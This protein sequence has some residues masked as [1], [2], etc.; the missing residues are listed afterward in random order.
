MELICVPRKIRDTR[1]LNY[2]R[3]LRRNMTA[4]ERRLWY[5]YLREHPMYRFRRQEIIGP[6]IADFYCARH[7]LVIEIDGS[8]HYEEDALAYDAARTAYF[9]RQQIRVIRFTTT[10]IN[11]RFQNVCETVEHALA[12]AQ[13]DKE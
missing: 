10:D 1:L 3:E 13:A 11:Q 12:A 4:E 9:H 2:A 5:M 6:Y 8:Q 7:R